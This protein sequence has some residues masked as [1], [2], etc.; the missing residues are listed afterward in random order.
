MSVAQPT[1]AKKEVIG[2]KKYYMHTVETGQT[3]FAL[4]NLYGV[5]KEEIVKNNPGSD[6]TLSVG[7]IV[8]IPVPVMTVYH[9]VLPKETVYAISKKYGVSVDDI[10]KSNPGADKGINVGQKVTIL[11]VDREI[12]LAGKVPEEKQTETAIVKE[13]VSPSLLTDTSSA[14]IKKVVLP[15]LKK[16]T[17]IQHKVGPKET[18]YTISK[19][20]MVT[21][22]ELKNLNGLKTTTIQPGSLL[23]IKVRPENA[24]PAEIRKV[25]E[26][27]GVQIDS[28]LL[29]P[30]KDGYKVGLF[31]PFFLDK[32]EGSS[33]YVSK[34]ATEF[35]M[36]AKM[37]I[38][39]LKEM[40][41]HADFY[42][43]DTRSDSVT[44]KKVLAKPEL[45]DMDLIIGPFYPAL[46]P[47]LARYCLKNQ[48][49]MV[50]PVAMQ[51]DI[52][53]NNPYVHLAVPSDARL[54]QSM[55]DFMLASKTNGALN[56]L[57]KSP[58]EKD[59]VLYDFFKLGYLNS[60]VSISKPKLIEATLSDFTSYMKKG[61]KIN[62]IFPTN[63]VKQATSFVTK[64]NSV[65][66]KYDENNIRIFAT[67]D[68]AAFDEIRG[69]FKN[70]FNLHFASPNDLNYKDERTM[71][72][73]RRYRI[74]YNADMTKMSV[75]GYDV[76]LGFCADFFLNKPQGRL[77][78]NRFEQVQADAG[79]GFENK[80][81]FLIEVE[82]YQFIN[83]LGK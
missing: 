57:I 44:L 51:T 11:N 73:L 70:K 21:V 66:D 18:L 22:D 38:D 50:C 78:M 35:Y 24:Q 83:V 2:G 67:K 34:L 62:L 60:T 69:Q 52:L 7:K 31:L 68:W 37:A 26:K 79:S 15:E 65:S 41:L 80:S 5:S 53:Q 71:N 56:I 55:A 75:Q 10:L 29:F 28:A 8:K 77:I 16:D 19:R 9:Q 42:V 81:A 14:E 27:L 43:Y 45:K 61:V 20:Y 36:G 40:G 59:Q 76:V 12:A 1:I 25:P 64:F 82:D 58:S 4:E 23:K 3:L 54:M 47:V 17:I 63:E 6:K 48:I 13:N 46:G 32:G 72:L 49:R 39:S 74:A 30:V 33:D